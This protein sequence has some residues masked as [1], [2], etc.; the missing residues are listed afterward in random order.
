MTYKKFDGMDREKVKTVGASLIERKE[1]PYALHVAEIKVLLSPP[2]SSL[3]PS[4]LP[5]PLSTHP[6]APFVRL[7]RHT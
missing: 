2:L 5:T 6:S 3:P 7:V 4:M 1:G